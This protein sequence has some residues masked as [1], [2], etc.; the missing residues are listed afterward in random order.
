ME[1]RIRKVKK[2]W[3]RRERQKKRRNIVVKRYKEKEID[4]KQN[5]GESLK[6]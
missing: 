1:E 3:D 4:E 2:M 6:K 5:R